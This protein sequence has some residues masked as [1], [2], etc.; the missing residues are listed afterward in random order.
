MIQV[1]Q[2]VNSYLKEEKEK[3][4]HL[5]SSFPMMQSDLNKNHSQTQHWLELIIVTRVHCCQCCKSEFYFKA[6]PDTKLLRTP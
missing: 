5:L 2:D 1:N 3:K 4:A 6:H